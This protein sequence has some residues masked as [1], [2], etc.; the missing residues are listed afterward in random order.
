MLFVNLRGVML[1]QRSFLLL[2][3]PEHGHWFLVLLALILLAANG[4]S[5]PS[6][7]LM[8]PLRSIKRV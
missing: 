5:K 4:S 7:V 2:L 8:A 3:T 6:I 1:W